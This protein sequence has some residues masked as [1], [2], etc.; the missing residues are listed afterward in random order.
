MRTRA[1]ATHRARRDASPRGRADG[2]ED[3][4]ADDRADAQER[5]VERAERALANLVPSAAA[6]MCRDF[7]AKESRSKA[8]PPLLR[9]VLRLLREPPAA[10]LTG[11][12]FTQRRGT[13]ATE[14]KKRRKEKAESSQSARAALN[15]LRLLL[16]FSVS[17]LPFP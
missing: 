7:C 12:S 9:I 3:A 4:R 8:L 17:Y 11:R 15:C 16:S 6:M 1:S 14:K 5:D 2:G 10:E 13:K